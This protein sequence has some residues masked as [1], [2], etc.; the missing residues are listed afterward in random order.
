MCRPKALCRCRYYQKGVNTIRG[1]WHVLVIS[2]AFGKY[3]NTKYMW[4]VLAL[5]YETGVDTN[6]CGKY[7]R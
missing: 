1:A 6:A 4:N 7:K 3:V 2:D 5:A